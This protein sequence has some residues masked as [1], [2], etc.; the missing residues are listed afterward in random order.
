MTPSLQQIEDWCARLSDAELVPIGWNCN[1]AHYLKAAGGRQAAYPFDWIFS[2]PG[3]VADA[4]SRRFD[5][6]IAPDKVLPI[7]QDIA[8]GHQRYHARMFNHGNPNATEE[9]R[10][11]YCRRIDRLLTVLDSA[12]PI[13][14][15]ATVLPEP[16]K[17]PAWRDGFVCNFAL[18][19][20]G[21]LEFEYSALRAF[22]AKRP[23]P[24]F[25][26]LLRQWTGQPSRSVTVTS[27]DTTTLLVDLAMTGVNDGVQF[28]DEADDACC[29]LIYAALASG[30]SATDAEDR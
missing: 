7:D 30:P 14:M 16:D 4:L 18:P 3:I 6:F 29:R 8:A 20:A 27:A 25:F 15:I 22:A 19:D 5:D 21:A 23:G 10:I 17:R 1:T 11:E 2:S 13:C 9:T 28:L 26:V 12:K 24:T